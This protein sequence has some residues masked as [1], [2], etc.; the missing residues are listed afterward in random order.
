MV[1][2]RVLTETGACIAGSSI[3]AAR[4]DDNEFEQQ[5]AHLQGGDYER[6]Y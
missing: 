2:S 5:V 1:V 4:R 6:I 3:R